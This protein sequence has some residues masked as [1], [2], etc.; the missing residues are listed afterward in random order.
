VEKRRP[1]LK[2]HVFEVIFEI[3]GFNR[4]RSRILSWN[5]KRKWEESCERDEIQRKWAKNRRSTTL[6]E[7]CS[8]MRMRNCKHEVFVRLVRT[9]VKVEAYWKSRPLACLDTD[10]LP[11]L[12]GHT[13]W[14]V[15]TRYS[16]NIL[17]AFSKYF[18][19]IFS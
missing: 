19:H 15:R 1:Y 6:T 5:P 16:E 9:R 17:W 11:S 8:D 2:D 4:L 14:S 3:G 7:A 13:S 12:S 18:S 10:P